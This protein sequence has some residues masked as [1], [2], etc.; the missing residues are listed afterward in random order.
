MARVY[1][2]GNMKGKPDL[3]REAFTK[4]AQQL[5][6]DDHEVFNPSAANLEGWSLDQ[7]MEYELPIICNWADAI[8]VLPNTKKRGGAKIEIELAKYLGREIIW[9]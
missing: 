1:I 4:A 6:K 3:N 5:R 8:A 7:I 9:L 2:C